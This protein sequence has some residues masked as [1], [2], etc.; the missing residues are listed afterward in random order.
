M[1]LTASYVLNIGPC[2]DIKKG[3]V[4]RAEGIIASGTA[5]KH[6]WYGTIGIPLTSL[7]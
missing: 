2:F 4:D 6:S 1:S 7:Q 3:R 5:G